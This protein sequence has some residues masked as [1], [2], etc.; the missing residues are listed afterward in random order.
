MKN[1]YLIGVLGWFIFLAA[2]A[3]LGQESTG[4]EIAGEES[5]FRQYR[6][7]VL[8]AETNDPLVFATLSLSQYNISTVTNS[9]GGFLLK[10]PE[11]ISE[12]VVEVAFLGYETRRI[13]LLQFTPEDNEI[14]LEVS[15]TTLPEVDVVVPRDAMTL[16]KE[17]L[18]KK[19]EN[20]FDNHTRM[21]AFYRETIK[22]RRRNVSLSEAVV[23]IY[24]TPYTS[25]RQDAMELYKARKSTDYD[26]L[27]TV[28]L[29]LQG[30][31]FNA[32]FVD[33]MK[34]PEYIFS[35]EYIEYYNFYFERNTRIDDR[36]IFVIGFEQKK[37]IA[38][39]LYRGKLYIDG[40]KK[41][42]TSAIFSLNITDE[43]MASR[44]FVRRKPSNAEVTPTEVSYRVDYRE[45]NGRWYYGYSNALLEFKINWD[46]K[47]FNSVYSLSCE[48]AV[49]DWEANESGSL[50]RNRERVKTSIILS[51]EAIGFSDPDF[52]G[53]YNIIEPDKSIESAIRKI[54]RQLRRE[55]RSS[56]G[57]TP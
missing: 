1:R 38:D 18:R 4:E 39:P 15:V 8:D 49:T 46:R 17:T 29:K 25:L 19:G 35:E 57:L 6:G 54:Q 12:A 56:P 22:K 33:V 20:Y 30:G 10:V 9:E 14:R 24:K 2:P 13:P 55:E 3:V 41:I 53:E 11:E 23:T 27:D 26:K 42:L 45:K 52:W 34:Y 31:P 32:L 37:H 7:E 43:Q 5:G 16:V 40:E 47:L 48:M 44:M 51:D 21:T 36:L 50:P 28:A